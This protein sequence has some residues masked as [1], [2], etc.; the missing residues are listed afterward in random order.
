MD[1]VTQSVNDF[2]RELASDSP[3]PGGGSVAAL[4]AAL[5][6]GLSAMV[7]HLTLNKKGCESVHQLMKDLLDE[8]LQLQAFFLRAIDEDAQSFNRVMSAMKLPKDSDEAKTFRHDQIQKALKEAS[9]VPLR[10]AEK[11]IKL[12]DF[13]EQLINEGNKNALTDALVCSMT[14]RT[15]ILGACL[16]VRINL[17]HLKDEKYVAITKLRLRQLED[18]ARFKESVILNM[19]SFDD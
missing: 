13:S 16:N 11:A 7:A 4:C 3:A 19:T 5:A 15:A 1:L 2:C 18:L 17:T 9:E 12:F 6:A 8:S 10:V 14:A